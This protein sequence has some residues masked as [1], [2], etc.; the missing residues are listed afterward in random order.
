[1]IEKL[2]PELFIFEKWEACW[3]EIFDLSFEYALD[4]TN[5]AKQLKEYAVG[6]CDG[7]KVIVRPNLKMYAVMFEKDGV[8]FWFHVDKTLFDAI[9]EDK[10]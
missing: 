7:S 3:W 2:N 9:R 8:E 1:M 10:I 4:D 5:L 6:Y